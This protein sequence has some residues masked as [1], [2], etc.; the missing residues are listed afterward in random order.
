MRNNDNE[1]IKDE[2]KQG[3]LVAD[4]AGTA[5]I[6]HLVYGPAGIGVAGT[7]ISPLKI[8]A[9]QPGRDALRRLTKRG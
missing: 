6:A 1:P 3:K 2:V 7:G 9:K 5:G 4:V 8:F